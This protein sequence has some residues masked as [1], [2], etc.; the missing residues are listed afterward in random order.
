[1]ALL[2][3][4]SS[5]NITYLNFNFKE[6]T[7]EQSISDPDNPGKK[8][9]INFPGIEGTVK[10]ISHKEKTYEGKPYDEIRINFTDAH[11]VSFSIGS[12]ESPNFGAAHFMASL[13]S[14]DFVKPFT[15]RIGKA[16][17]GE[18]IG[19]TIVS[20]DFVWTS[21]KQNDVK[22]PRNYGADSAN[23]EVLTKLPEPIN[24][25]KNKEGKVVYADNTP[26]REWLEDTLELLFSRVEDAKQ[27]LGMAPNPNTDLHED[28]INFDSLQSEF[29][30]AAEEAAGNSATQQVNQ[31]PAA[32][33]SRLRQSA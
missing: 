12:N 6:G 21:V 8:M 16:L 20:K 33:P 5:E 2:E 29:Q 14:V 27:R 7:L 31:A 17:A 10:S 30:A 15:I 18:K 23:G 28:G 11:S 9:K 1:M 19:D 24:V 4:H 26:T 25:V 13:R 22:L 3:R 32:R